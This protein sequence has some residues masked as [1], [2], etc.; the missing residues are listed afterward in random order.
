MISEPQTSQSPPSSYDEGN[1]HCRVC[2]RNY[3]GSQ[4]FGIE[5]CRACAAFFRR[6]VNGGKTFVCRRGGNEC[7]LNTPRKITCQQCRWMKCLQVGM[8]KELVNCRNSHEAPDLKTTA[9][10]VEPPLKTSSCHQMRTLAPLNT[11]SANYLIEALLKSTEML[12]GSASALPTVRLPRIAIAR[13]SGDISGTRYG[14]PFNEHYSQLEAGPLS[15]SYIVDHLPTRRLSQI[16]ANYFVPGIART[17]RYEPPP[18]TLRVR[19]DLGTTRRVDTTT[20]QIP[21]VMSSD[22]LADYLNI[23]DYP[24]TAAII[25]AS[26]NQR[27]LD[28]ISA[29][30]E[31]LRDVD[32]VALFEN[33]SLA[34]QRVAFL[35]C[36]YPALALCMVSMWMM[37]GRGLGLNSKDSRENVSY[38]VAFA[39]G[40]FILACNVFHS[41]SH[42]NSYKFAKIMANLY[43]FFGLV[44][45][46]AAATALVFA[47]IAVRDVSGITTVD[48]CRWNDPKY[49]GY[50]GGVCFTPSQRVVFLSVIIGA[51]SWVVLL[52]II[53]FFYGVIGQSLMK[54]KRRDEFNRFARGQDNASFRGKGD[55]PMTEVASPTVD[56]KPCFGTNPAIFK[57][58]LGKQHVLAHEIGQGSQCRNAVDCSCEG[59]DL[60]FWRKI[61]KNCGCRMDEHDVVLPN[62]FDHAQ[63]VIGR[64]FGAKEH[65]ENALKLGKS[66][67]F[68]ETSNSKKE[69]KPPP[70]AVY[71]FKMA[72]EQENEKENLEYSW[73]PLPDKRLVE[74]YM[75]ALPLEERPIIGSVGEQNRKS[76]LQ[77]Q[78]PLY[79]CNVEDARFVEEKDKKTLQKFVD[80][81]RNNVIGVGKV[82]EVG[83]SETNESLPI[84]AQVERLRLGEGGASTECKECQKGMAAGDI[85]VEC[86]HATEQ[87]TWHPSCFKCATCQQLLVDN[88][89]FF[90]QSKYYCGRHYADQLYPRCAGCDELIF[91]NEY[92][93]AEEKS[94]HFDHFACYKCDFKL[95]GSRYMTRE[96]NPY[97]LEC[98]LTY[99]AKTCDT[100]QQKIGPDEKRLNYNDVHWHA[101]EKCFQCV[102]CRENLIGKKFML[103]N[104]SLFCSSQCRNN[105]ISTH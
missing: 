18:P 66:S 8:Q 31:S 57:L 92:T 33:S 28:E 45:L 46:C 21:R 59:L 3:D 68:S 82:I 43:H 73:A 2:N 84:E 91:A 12:D 49:T 10:I 86:I 89:Y 76:R 24:M 23:G 69:N 74:K 51:A 41:H 7:Q 54:K 79:D 44:S 94:W 81:V 15:P 63:I 55:V 16:S 85:G 20:D 39:S 11:R 52:A 38:I 14:R 58:G 19:T 72:N 36:R 26:E 77:F 96:N 75:K 6:S 60:H 100:C 61:C 80:N 70:T 48:K 97:C 105:F 98:Y 50:D 90:Y 83:H 29:R 34:Y 40:A 93:F 37:W 78:L 5:V 102:Q 67:P 27:R 4:H 95:G 35:F 65:F 53:A 64:L 104:H 30:A 25:G 101:V 17:N 47:A 88:I 1:I 9:S 32:R 62:E 103:K 13:P 22:N 87:N 99:F 42:H 71:N 56:E